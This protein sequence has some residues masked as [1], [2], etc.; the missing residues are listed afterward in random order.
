MR[1]SALILTGK[2]RVFVK[3]R[4]KYPPPI[5]RM[6]TISNGKVDGCSSV[7]TSRRVDMI[8]H[9]CMSTG[10]A[11]DTVVSYVVCVR[12]SVEL[13]SSRFHC[14]FPPRSLF[15]D[16]LFFLFICALGC[17]PVAYSVHLPTCPPAHLPTCPPA[18]LQT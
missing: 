7:S 4:T 9:L 6:S 2:Y 8:N 11:I 18:H 10:G 1:R 16:S 5:T 17:M 14:P 12:Q 15:N 3:Q 13:C